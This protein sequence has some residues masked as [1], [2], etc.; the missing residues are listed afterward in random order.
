MSKMSKCNYIR[1]INI[2][3][4]IKKVKHVLYCEI[5]FYRQVSLQFRYY[6]ETSCVLIQIYHSAHIKI[7]CQWQSWLLTLS[8]SPRVLQDAFLCIRNAILAMNA[9]SAREMLCLENYNK[10]CFNEN[11]TALS[12]DS[13]F[14]KEERKFRT[15]IICNIE[16]HM[17]NLSQISFCFV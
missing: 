6:H 11:E 4:F 12:V 3:Q 10:E 14:Y 17:R 9:I 13:E 16:L 2:K 1:Y 5:F 15:A 8:N 7:K